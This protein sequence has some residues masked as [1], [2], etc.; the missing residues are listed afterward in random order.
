MT[1][2]LA[3]GLAQPLAALL[4]ACICAALL[5]AAW[6]GLL[7]DTAAPPGQHRRRPTPAALLIGALCFIAFMTEGA[8][9]DWSA[10]FLR[11]NRAVPSA[12][13]G[14]GYAAFSVAMA[15]GRLTGDAVIR[16]L[17]GP[18]V[19]T[20]SAGLA[21]AGLLLAVAVPHA[22][23]A[24]AGFVL[25]GFGAANVVPTLFSAAGRLP[26]LPAHAALPIV[27]AIGYSGL[28]AGPV[29]IGPIAALIG[30]PASLG[31]V[32][33]AMLVIAACNG[34]ARSVREGSG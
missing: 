2:L 10:V 21:C 33:I 19:L 11:F 12:S 15:I 1:V 17:G 9:L 5:L 32:G 6:P 31:G 13:A 26:D 24:L 18:R 4:S 29:L 16:R 7:R 23:A 8:I 28:L 3:G 22:A 27:N 30:L 20:L 34:V 14:L 25:V